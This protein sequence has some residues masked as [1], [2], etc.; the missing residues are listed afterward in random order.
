M[1]IVQNGDFEWN[2]AWLV[3]DTPLPAFYAGPPP[4]PPSGSRM[5]ALGAILPGSPTNVPAYSS[6]QQSVTLPATA[7][8]AQI[9]FSYYPISN[10]SGG[11]DR[12]ELILL[13]PLNYDETIA[14]LWRVT[15]NDNRWLNLSLDLTRY[16]G[17][18]VAIY[19]NARNAG[20]GTRT[21]MY[22]DQ[23]QVLVCYAA[24]AMPLVDGKGGYEQMP[25]TYGDSYPTAG[26]APAQPFAAPA[27]GV[28]A[29]TPGPTVISVGEQPAPLPEG[30]PAVAPAPATEP[31]E[32]PRG[33]LGSALG[34][35]SA[36]PWLIIIVISVIVLVA[37]VAALVVFREK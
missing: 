12:Q 20:D 15:A 16:L 22:L 35:L 18:T 33:E 13:D 24:A 27:V 25:S 31:S 30:A 19:F 8:T 9:S 32:T 17:R 34:N 1:D 7:Q 21:A 2:G 29:V 26:P 10:A 37:V 14:V 3:G 5:M 11:F 36:S 28:L 6:I 4:T 23:V